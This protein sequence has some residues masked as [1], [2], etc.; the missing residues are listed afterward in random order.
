MAGQ[1]RAHVLDPEVTLHHRL[2]QIAQCRRHCGDDAEDQRVG[3]TAG[4]IA[5]WSDTDAAD[6]GGGD[7]DADDR[8][9]DH[10]LER[11]VRAVGGQGCAPHRAPDDVGTDVIA[12]RC[13]DGGEEQTGTQR[14]EL[15][16]AGFLVDCDGIARQQQTTERPENAHVADSEQGDAEVRHRTAGPDGYEVPEQGEHHGQEEDHRI[17]G[18]ALPVRAHDQPDGRD[19]PKQRRR[20]VPDLAHGVVELHRGQR[21]DGGGDDQSWHLADPQ[22]TQRRRGQGKPGDRC[23]GDVT[24]GTLA[25]ARLG[26]RRPIGSSRLRRF[27]CGRGRRGRGRG[28]EGTL[29]GRFDRFAGVDRRIETEEH[30]AGVA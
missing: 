25:L 28:I 27:R 18:D 14:L 6:D 30:V 23:H 20:V 22:R 24:V 2:A 21:E 10:T 9:P 29:G 19:Q 11:L 5:P 13:Q 4:R 3:E 7:D 8:S 16:Q 15:D 26:G 17:R 1:H 12:D